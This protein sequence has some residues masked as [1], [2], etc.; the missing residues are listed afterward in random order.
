MRNFIICHSVDERKKA[1]DSGF[2]DG[3]RDKEWI[4]VGDGD[5]SSIAQE[6]NVIIARDLPDNIED[7]KFLCS[8]TGWYALVKNGFITDDDFFGLFEYDIHV[9]KR[10]SQHVDARKSSRDVIGFIAWKV[11]RLGYFPRITDIVRRVLK[12]KYDIDFD[13]FVQDEIAAG[14]RLWCPSTNVVASGLFFRSF[15]EWFIPLIDFFDGKP[16]SAYVHERAMRVFSA[17]NGYDT[18]CLI[19]M[20]KH[21]QKKSH[22]IQYVE[23]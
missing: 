10:F 6:E 11:D 1:L 7:K 13:A 16:E 8:F 14:H 21:I 4:M 19:G 20:L 15:V 18:V 9:V 3:I 12:D 22:G 5:F 23:Y 17:L 2:I